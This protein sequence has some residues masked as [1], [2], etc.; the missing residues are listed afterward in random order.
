LNMKKESEKKRE[1]DWCVRK[2]ALKAFPLK[3][4]V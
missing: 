1:G 4:K 3:T 2:K